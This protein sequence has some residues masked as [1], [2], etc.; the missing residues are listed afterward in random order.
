MRK[1]SLAFA[2][3]SL[4]MF[5][6]AQQPAAP[7]RN[8]GSADRPDPPPNFPPSY[9][10]HI[11]PTGMTEAG[12]NTSEDRNYWVAR[13]WDLKNMIAEAWHVDES[14]LDA[15][16]AVDLGKRYDFA[17]VFPEPTEDRNVIY[18]YVRQAIQDQ[19]HLHIAPEAEPKDVYVLTAP[20]GLSTAVKIRPKMTNGVLSSGMSM[21]DNSLSAG[22]VR[23]E[24]LCHMV[25]RRL[26]RLVVDETNVQDRFD[27]DV[28]GEGRG[29]DAF[30]AML[31]DKIGLVLTPAHRDVEMLAIRS[32]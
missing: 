27:V 7:A 26:G 13:G 10:V 9:E 29:R 30:I 22:G 28:T 5:A 2:F 8:R 18:G 15:A 32:M 1:L 19:F 20:N 24:D 3:A 6:V 25:E 17:M 31:R 23:M 12:T 14:R 16:T 4:A 11:S 21:N